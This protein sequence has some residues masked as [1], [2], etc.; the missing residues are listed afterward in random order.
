M[1]DARTVIAGWPEESK[2]AAGLVLDKYGTPDEITQHQLVWHDR[3]VWNRIVATRAF[4][5][6]D[7][8]TTHYDSVEGIIDYKVPPDKVSEI[9]RFDGS[10]DAA[11]EQRA[12]HAETL[13]ARPTV[14]LPANHGAHQDRGSLGA[15]QVRAARQRGSRQR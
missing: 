9:A 13:V 11:V 7:F 3:G 6:H 5:R 14:R 2:E 15:L 8:P 12:A 4:H 10:V 1:D